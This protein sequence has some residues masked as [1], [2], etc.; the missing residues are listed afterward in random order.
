AVMLRQQQAAG[1]DNVFRLAVEQADGFNILLQ[2]ALPELEDGGRGVGDRKQF[3]GSLVDAHIGGL[4]R[5]HYRNQQFERRVV[6]QFGGGFRVGGL[7]A[8]ENFGA[9]LFVHRE[10]SALPR[11]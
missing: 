3:G 11:S 2:A 4:R 9:F 10:E 6:A 7:Q 5:K 1:S 8:A